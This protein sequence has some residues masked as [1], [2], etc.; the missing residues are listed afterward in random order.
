MKKILIVE[1]DADVASLIERGLREEGF[2]PKITANAKTALRLLSGKWHVIILDL[3]LPDLPGESILKF[4]N[5]DSYRPPV[6]ILTASGEVETK[7]ELFRQGCDDYLIKPFVF[8]E[9][10]ARVRALLKRPLRVV[11]DQCQYEDMALVN[12]PHGLIIGDRKI[13]LSPKEYAICRLLLGEPGKIVSRKELLHTVWGY[14]E[15]SNTNFLEVHLAHLRKKLRP[16]GRD[17]WVQTV[18]NS[19]ITLSRPH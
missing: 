18:R 1:D 12:K 8:D 5:H 15:E 3:R 14:A 17:G 10:L 7:L 9:L 19:G 16:F 2:E 13:P 4:L 11:P 6:L